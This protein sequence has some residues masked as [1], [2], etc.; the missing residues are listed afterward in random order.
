M[1]IT[2]RY[3]VISL[4]ALPARH[5]LSPAIHNAAFE[6][7]GLPYV[8]VAFEVPEEAL[9]DAVLGLKALGIKG[10]SVSMPY[11]QRIIPYLNEIS[12]AAK[13]TGAV[14]TIKITDGKL[15]GCN[16]DGLGHIGALKSK[17][18]DIK[19][20]K[21]VIAG[22]GGAGKAI[23]AEAAFKG[24]KEISVFNRAGGTNFV[25]ALKLSDKLSE[26]T[27]IRPAVYDLED[28]EKLYAEIASADIFTNATSIGMKPRDNES[29]TAAFHKGLAVF[30][31]VYNPVKT[32][33]L[34]EAE[35]FGCV[36][37]NGVEML[38]HQGAE[39]FKIWTGHPFP[40]EYVRNAIA[41]YL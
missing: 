15:I 14:N 32:K 24:A 19:G 27:G 13:L 9:E 23:I 22:A 7:L 35:D 8:Y 3:E 25:E 11:K 29:I 41:K 26:A 17:G 38:L 20:S 39:Q 18:I 40:M 2:A 12:G 6:K 30:D 16:T 31:S 36:T 10:A 1:N 4:L 21:L 34:T 5:S 28:K 37:V 33:L